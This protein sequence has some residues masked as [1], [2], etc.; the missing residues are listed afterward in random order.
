MTVHYTP[1][2]AVDSLTNPGDPPAKIYVKR[3]DD[4]RKDPTIIGANQNLFGSTINN[5]TTS[6]DVGLIIASAV[7]DALKKGGATADLHS[8]RQ[9]KDQVPE[10][11]MHGY[12]TVVGG[13]VTVIEVNTKP[14][15][16]T[17]NGTARIAIRVSVTRG[18]KTEWIGPI[19]GTATSAAVMVADLT[20]IMSMSLDGAIQN[21]MR[22]MIQH[23]K[24]GGAFST[25]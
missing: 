12:D 23:L 6:D 18:G 20:N 25:R 17:V 1:I 7:T 3:F 21:C 8:D 24:A 2:S 4:P 5:V 19:E 10:S 15:W 14:G 22:T 9:P 11:E 16:N 13:E